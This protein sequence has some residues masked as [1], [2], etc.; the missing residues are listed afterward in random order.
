M[1]LPLLGNAIGWTAAKIFRQPQPDVVTIA[2]ETG[3]QNTG[4]TMFL[5]VFALEQPAADITLVV[6]IGVSILTPIPLITFVIIKKT[7]D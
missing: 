5:V 2:I 7:R 1:G 6:P 3:V 4:L